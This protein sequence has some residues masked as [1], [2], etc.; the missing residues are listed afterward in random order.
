[1]DDLFI[2]T[3]SYDMGTAEP[4]GI[5]AADLNNDGLEDVITANN[6]NSTI[7]VFLSNGDYTFRAASY[8]RFDGSRH[9]NFMGL[10][11]GD[12]NSDGF[13]DAVV[14]GHGGPTVFMA[15]G[16]GVFKKG[17]YYSN[18]D[19]G[20]MEN[21][22]QLGDINNDGHLDAVFTYNY[23]NTGGGGICEMLGK[24]DGTLVPYLHLTT[25]NVPYALY[26][27]DVNH[28]NNLDIVATGFGDY[29][30]SVFLG[31][32]NG[33][34]RPALASPISANTKSIALNDLNGDSNLDIVGVSSDGSIS[35]LLGYGN[36]TFMDTN[37]YSDLIWGGRDLSLADFNNDNKVDLAI[38]QSRGG[39]V[40]LLGYGNGTF[41][42]RTVYNGGQSIEHITTADLTNNNYY[43]IIVSDT[44][45]GIITFPNKGDG[46]F[47]A[48]TG[49]GGK[50]MV[51]SYDSAIATG[52]L[53]SDGLEDVAIG[54][55]TRF[56]FLGMS[57]FM[58]MGSNKFAQPIQYGSVGHNYYG[59]AIKDVNN[60][61]KLDLVGSSDYNTMVLLGNGDGTLKSEMLS[62]Y[63][64]R[65]AF[66]LEDVNN[67]DKLDIVSSDIYGTYSALQQ[68]SV[69][70]GYG[71][72]TFQ[73]PITFK[74]GHFNKLALGDINKDGKLDII[75]GDSGGGAAAFSLFAGNG[76]GTFQA[77]IASPLDI[78]PYG[79]AI[80]DINRDSNL[81]AIFTSSSNS[82][83]KVK[84]AISVSLG[85]GNGTFQSPIVYGDYVGGAGDIVL[86]DIN[87]DDYLD[88]ITVG[89]NQR[90]NVLFGT[91]VGNF[92][93]QAKYGDNGIGGINSI[94]STDVNGDNKSDI[95]TIGDSYYSMFTVLLNGCHDNSCVLPTTTTAHTTYTTTSTSAAQI[96]T[97][98]T[99]STSSILTPSTTSTDPTGPSIS[100]TMITTSANV[101][102]DSGNS[103]AL[104]MP[105]II[106]IAVGYVAVL[107]AVVAGWIIYN[108]YFKTLN[109]HPDVMYIPLQQND[110]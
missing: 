77:A 100:T 84:C 13:I 21:N 76:N 56:G 33:T 22:I 104:S 98:S 31:Y 105:A 2:T 55:G 58:N 42:Q 108:K 70:L 75:A 17:I 7:S 79:V 32:G 71:N 85:N 14:G 80:A 97:S 62:P 8:G 11:L 16:D 38:S 39:I 5:A 92:M 27:G 106:G 93:N 34:F 4:Y 52:D 102:P 65:S 44:N 95:V 28:D 96:K 74:T 78:I 61:G 49:F 101:V 26:V 46:T 30:V 72:G 12:L 41:G 83:S 66:V 81:D 19:C 37:Y 86:N 63:S 36:G 109:S 3:L 82:N 29:I 69:L 64:G 54:S 57:V 43:D 24:G 73:T 88:A 107:T 68:I 94:V 48:V 53:N 103:G 25:N 20:F 90:V 40:F 47:R 59:V 35:V 9:E 89:Y 1:M 18:S 15:S 45:L 99:S 67:D 50:E 51:S 23:S 87:G 10:A 91:K 60:D 6:D 110:A